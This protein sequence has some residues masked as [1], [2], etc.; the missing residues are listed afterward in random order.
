MSVSA[1]ANAQ[2]VCGCWRKRGGAGL[3][4]AA[5]QPPARLSLVSRRPSPAARALSTQRERRGA[6]GDAFDKERVLG[7]F[8]VARARSPLRPLRRTFGELGELGR[9][10]VY[11]PPDERRLAGELG[12]LLPGGA[13]GLAAR[14]LLRRRAVGLRALARELALQ[15]IRH[16]AQLRRAV[17]AGRHGR[18]DAVAGRQRAHGARGGTARTLCTAGSLMKLNSVYAHLRASVEER[19]WAWHAGAARAGGTHSPFVAGCTHPP[20]NG[21]GQRQPACASKGPK[22][23]KHTVYSEQQR[24][25]WQAGQAQAAENAERLGTISRQE[26][27]F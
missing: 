20:T 3:S 12:V 17:A 5:R 21:G 7:C 25:W 1:R 10:G 19:S 27:R 23:A 14:R 24:R 16:R 11:V 9:G 26:E 8:L 13:R 2:R 22:K 15:A 4:P 18:R 6:Q